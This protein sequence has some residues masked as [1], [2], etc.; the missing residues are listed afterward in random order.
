MVNIYRFF[1]YWLR[2]EPVGTGRNQVTTLQEIT[3]IGLM[4]GLVTIGPIN[5][6]FIFRY[7]LYAG[8]IL[9]FADMAKDFRW[10]DKLFNH[11][12]VSRTPIF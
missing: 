12:F 11:L 6:E 9:A 4:I 2:F 8:M 3:D 10:T 5:E 1:P 7:F